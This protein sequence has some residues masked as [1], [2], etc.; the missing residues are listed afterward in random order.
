[1]A[2]KHLSKLVV[3]TALFGLLMAGSTAMAAKASKADKILDKVSKE[4]NTAMRNVRWA[5]VA[6]FDGQPQIAEKML[7]EAKKNLDATEKQAP[8]LLVALKSKEKG[9]GVKPQ[10]NLIPIDAWLVLSED[11][12][13]TPGKT[14]KIKEANE[15][16]KKGARGKA[17][18]VLRA[19]DIGVA[20]TRILMPLKATIKNVDTA[21]TLLKAHKYYEANLALKGAQDGLIM[22]TVGLDEPT[23]PAK[24]ES[25]SKKK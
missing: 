21:S 11:Y 9:T 8:Q 16:L 4:G 20:I 13:P 10:T 1:M 25:A 18:E 12:V 7:D 19:A 17:V 2:G 23:V 5:R 14:A 3:V 24:K 22:D 15:H 6:I